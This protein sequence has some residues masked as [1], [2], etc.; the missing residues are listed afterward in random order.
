MGAGPVTY[1]HLVQGGSSPK[2]SPVKV[3]TDKSMQERGATPAA[4]E[5]PIPPKEGKSQKLQ[6]L[7]ARQSL[8]GKLGGNI[9]NAESGASAM[10]LALDREL[11][12]DMPELVVDMGVADSSDTES[13]CSSSS[14]WLEDGD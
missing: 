3:P 1:V 8:A 9:S 10:N 14:S 5:L 11:Y 13:T 2:S 7:G 12:R 4:Q 6:G